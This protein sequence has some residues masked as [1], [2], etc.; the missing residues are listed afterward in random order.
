MVEIVQCTTPSHLQ[1]VEKKPNP[2]T[3][4]QA[5]TVESL[6]ASIDRECESVEEKVRAQELLRHK[7]LVAKMK[8]TEAE[9][10]DSEEEE[11]VDGSVKIELGVP[12]KFGTDRQLSSWRLW[13]GGKMGGRPVWLKAKNLPSLEQV[14]CTHCK[15]PMLFLSQ[16]YA[17]VQGFH[18]V[19][20]VYCCRRAGCLRKCKGG[21]GAIRV[22]RQQLAEKDDILLEEAIQASP[23]AVEEL[24]IDANDGEAYRK[25]EFIEEYGG[26]VEWNT[27]ME[28]VNDDNIEAQKQME[29][30]KRK[31]EEML[32]KAKE[33]GNALF[34]DGKY[35]DAA[36]M[37]STALEHI[38]TLRSIFPLMSEKDVKGVATAERVDYETAKLYGNRSAAFRK[39][40]KLEKALDDAEKGCI[41]H[42]SWWKIHKRR[43]DVLTD[44]CKD[45]EAAAVN[46]LSRKL[47]RSCA[48]GKYVLDEFELFCEPEP[49]KDE[50][51]EAWESK[52]KMLEE[53]VMKNKK[54]MKERSSE[55][56][57][58]E[59]VTRRDL[60]EAAG[61][62]AKRICNDKVVRT[63]QRRVACVPE[64]CVRYARWEASAVLWASSER[65]VEEN[66]ENCP[67]CNGER[68]FEFQLM[69]QL[70]HFCKLGLDD[71]SADWDT[72]ICYTC[73]NL[74]ESGEETA[75]VQT[76]KD[77]FTC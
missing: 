12:E 73:S 30:K 2:F 55:N 24:R 14:H 44:L 4:I 18:R 5:K 67:H 53:Q 43:A 21:A 77:N 65:R 35:E 70:L 72:I 69:P 7:E 13:H 29:E 17:P 56:E 31:T 66:V 9:D 58:K 22:I 74:C 63:F 75:W 20:Y 61:D 50:R 60:L 54:N 38:H 32:F 3:S 71:G 26:T 42:P 8:I 59:D 52:D 19:L 47:K 11:D 36:E 57:E 6:T 51:R 39:V 23:T 48:E 33:K 62:A 41:L 45:D 10:S 25:D 68:K 1:S 28:V 34:K 64:Q 76:S 49:T 46:E 37:Y 16:L 27:S 40:G 15:E